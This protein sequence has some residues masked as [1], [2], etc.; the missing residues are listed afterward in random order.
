MAEDN[1]AWSE[2]NIGRSSVGRTAK[3]P[4]KE[5]VVDSPL[6][7]SKSMEYYV[8]RISESMME[9]TKNEKSAISREQDE[10]TELLQLAEQDGV[11]NGSE[12]YFMA[13]ELFRTPA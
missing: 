4:G 8:E 12:L 1:N 7:K 2:D 5:K 13:A 11:P 6:K 3:R 10:V 9:R